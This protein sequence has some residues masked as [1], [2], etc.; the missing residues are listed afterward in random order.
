MG[1]QG[2]RPSLWAEDVGWLASLSR[3]D[4]MVVAWFCV[5]LGEALELDGKL[6]VSGQG[7]AETQNF[8]HWT[9]GRF[10]ENPYRFIIL[11]FTPG[12]RLHEA[13]RPGG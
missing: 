9:S 5:Q 3:C 10:M 6:D 4:G 8:A 1:F 13:T 12:V 2:L 7:L 11:L